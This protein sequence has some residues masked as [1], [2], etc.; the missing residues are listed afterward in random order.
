MPDHC[1]DAAYHGAIKD[2]AVLETVTLSEFQRQAGNV[3]D[4][5]RGAE[6]LF[7]EEYHLNDNLEAE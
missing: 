6:T 4:L 3:T 1:L 2:R 7:M 5:A